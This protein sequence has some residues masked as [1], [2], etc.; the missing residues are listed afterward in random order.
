M[1][2]S[3]TRAQ[4]SLHL[5][6]CRTRRRAGEKVDCVASRFVAEL[7]QD[8]VRYADQPSTAD[9]AVKAKQTGNARLAA[10]K[11]LVARE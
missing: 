3:L 1:P 6:H 4:Q 5:S 8:D 2:H 11:T 10:L 9:E 7:A